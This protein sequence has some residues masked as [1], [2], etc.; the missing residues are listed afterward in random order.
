[1]KTYLIEATET[2]STLYHVQAND[3]EEARDN[4]Y[5][6]INVTEVT[7]RASDYI[8]EEVDNIKEVTDNNDR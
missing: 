4:F 7:Q 1:M 3:I 5:D 2:R 8:T 6:W